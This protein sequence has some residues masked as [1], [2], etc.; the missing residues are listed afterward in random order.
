MAIS[1]K[2]LFTEIG[3]ELRRTV[4]AALTKLQ[5]IAAADA[6]QPLAPGKWS[7]KQVIGHLID[8]AANNHQ[9]F[10]RGQQFDPLVLPGYTQDHWVHSQHY[11]DRPWVDVVGLWHAY[12][13]H[14]AHVITHIPEERRSVSCTIGTDAPVTLAYLANDYIV[15]MRHHLAQLV[16]AP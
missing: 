5:S 14:L 7:A 11:Q 4:D 10:V 3:A 13:R 12:N 16:A 2:S 1:E 9:R 8:S 6:D 15:H